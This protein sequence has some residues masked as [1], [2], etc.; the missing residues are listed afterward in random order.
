MME[1][2]PQIEIPPGCPALPAEPPAP[3]AS[4]ITDKD[5]L[6]Y[7]WKHFALIADQRVKTFNFY[8]IVLL[9]A[10]GATVSAFKPPLHRYLYCLIGTGHMFIAIVFGMIEFRGKAILEISREALR[11]IESSPAFGTGFKPMTTE[12]E[13]K[14]TGI[15]HYVTYGNA[16]TLIFAG[17]FLFGFLVAA[18]PGI[19]VVAAGK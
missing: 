8:I 7:Y 13:S 12:H 11:Q 4:T 9:A 15:R 6:D 17:H 3:T 16:F 19:F 18:W 14:A 1:T 5:R 10:F 2:S